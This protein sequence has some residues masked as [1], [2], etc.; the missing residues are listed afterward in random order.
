MEALAKVRG[1]APL[2]IRPATWLSPSFSQI[3]STGLVDVDEMV[4]CEETQSREATDE[5]DEEAEEEIEEA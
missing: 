3:T 1:Q 2:G 4:L 5:D